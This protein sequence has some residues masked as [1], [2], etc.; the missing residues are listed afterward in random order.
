MHEGGS[1]QQQLCMSISDRDMRG[2]EKFDLWHEIA[3]TGPVGQEAITGAAATD[4]HFDAEMVI[5]TGL[6]ILE[7]ALSSCEIVRDPE[8]AQGFWTDPGAIV[9]FVTQGRLAIEQDGRSA[10][11]LPGAA[12][13]CVS[14][15]PYRLRVEDGFRA[16]VLKFDRRLLSMA[17]DLST[18]TA[19]HL[20]DEAN[21]AQLLSGFAQNVARSASVR[22][23]H[24]NAR[25]MRAFVDLLETGF[26]AMTHGEGWRRPTHRRAT[27]NRVAAFVRAHLHDPDLTPGQV[28]QRLKL[29]PRYL[30]KVFA[31]EGTSLGRFIWEL[32][33]ARGAAD[34]LDPALSHD[35]ITMIALRNGFKDLSHFSRMFRARFDQSPTDYRKT[36]P[37]A[38]RPRLLRAPWSVV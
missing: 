7:V 34:L 37:V 17:S 23:A 6:G 10:V 31:A 36:A 2:R 20:R 16:T 28:A 30:N 35:Q 5:Q 29:S 12:A 26:D 25:L 4:F 19:L 13:L 32:R 38:V 24:T 1:T 8:K 33:I 14:D 27:F 22:S 15:R 18:F 21:M 9:S 11:L 3:R